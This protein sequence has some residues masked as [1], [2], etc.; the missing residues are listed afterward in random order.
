MK[1]R[2]SLRLLFWETTAGC[3]LR[4]IHCRASARPGRLPDELTT[5]EALELVDQIASFS[6]P[7]LVLSGGEPLFRNDIFEI[8]TYASHKGLR[9]ALAT[10][11]T[12][13]TQGKA[14]R[15]K[16]AG[17]GRTS[18]SLDG[19][20]ALTHDSFRGV[21]GAFDKAVEGI[22]NLREAGVEFQINTTVTS[23]N[24]RELPLILELARSL[25]AAAFHIFLLVPVGCGLEISEEQQIS[26]DEYE[27]VL[28]WLYEQS[29]ESSLELKATC[30]PHYFRILNQRGGQA[31]ARRG[32]GGFLARGKQDEHGMSAMTKGC[33]AGS[34][35]CFVSY[36]GDVQPCGYLPLKAGNVLENP[37]SEIW[38][39]SELFATLRD[40]DIL[41]GKCGYC[42]F[43]R[44]CFG[45]R[46]RAYSDTGNYLAE[47]P[48]CV[49]EP[50]IPAVAGRSKFISQ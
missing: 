48:Y 13:V 6:S 10:N 35:V 18:V 46:A 32:R 21:S 44:V 22:E 11:G 7:I 36:R 29:R 31:G 12:L 40:P 37:L 27:R 15:L 17:I 30:A 24:V 8:A 16:K 1:N 23:H 5:K 28:S 26:P 39:F 9:V 49:Y 25:G 33:L 19:A 20:S 3:N 38:E 47:E 2:H 14:G 50:P 34:A 42:E 41:G 43:R 45:C 4:C